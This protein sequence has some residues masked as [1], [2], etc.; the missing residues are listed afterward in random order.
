MRIAVS[1]VL[2]FYLAAAAVAGERIATPFS[3]PADDVRLALSPDGQWALWGVGRSDRPSDIVFSRKT[4][5]GWSAPAPVPFNSPRNDFDPAFSADGHTVY[6][7]S[8]RDGG[9]GKSDLYEIA[10][11][12]VSGKWGEA[13]NLGANVNSSGDEW[14][15]SVTKNGNVLLFSSDGHGGY[16]K[17]D[18]FL[19]RKANGV[20]GVPENL[21]PGINSADEEFDAAF[22]PDERTIVFAKGTFGAVT[23]VRLHRGERAGARWQDKGELS[24]EINCGRHLNFGPSFPASEPGTFYWSGDCGDGRG[25]HDIWH[26]TWP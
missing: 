10:F 4:P 11:D 25:D 6:F 3:G 26:I 23:K 5:S 16:G 13:A 19:S 15:P 24:A 18:L 22:T 9:Y 14:A 1:A 7:F 8:D 21:G 20:W 17:H 12:P 2:A